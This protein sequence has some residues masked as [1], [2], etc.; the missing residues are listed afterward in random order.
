MAVVRGHWVLRFPCVQS[1][2]SRGV[3]SGEV[4]SSHRGQRRRGR[5]LLGSLL[6]VGWDG[7]KNQRSLGPEGPRE[8]SWGK[9]GLGKFEMKAS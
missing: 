4:V 2:C 5:G 8:P 7:S 6:T 9:W 1:A 3:C